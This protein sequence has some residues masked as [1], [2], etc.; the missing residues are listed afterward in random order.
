MDPFGLPEE[1]HED[2][3]AFRVA[4]NE[5]PLEVAI[6]H[7][8]A[9]KP[10]RFRDF[11]GLLGKGKSDTPLTRVLHALAEDGLIDRGMTSDPDDVEFRYNLTGLGVQVLFRSHEFKDAA[12]VIKDLRKSRVL[13]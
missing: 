1:G 13:A 6:L 11:K 7:R 9:G 12:T 8:L 10:R 2:R 3:L 4:G 5:N